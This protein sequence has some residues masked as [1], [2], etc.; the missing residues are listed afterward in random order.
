MRTR[1]R[2][3][4]LAV[5]AASGLGA[6]GLARGGAGTPPPPP[7][8]AAASVAVVVA[9]PTPVPVVVRTH[10]TVQ[11]RTQIELVAEVPGRVARVAPAL[12]A[13]G[14]FEAGDVLLELDDRDLRLALERALAARQ[15]RESER[16]LRSAEHRRL[17]ALAARE[18]ASSAR[19]EAAA[20]AERI[21]EAVLR[22]AR[23]AAAQARHD[24]ERARIRAP[25]AGRVGSRFADV[26]SFVSRGRAVARIYATDYAEVRLPVPTAEL[27]HLELPRPDLRLDAEAGGPRVRLEAPFAGRLGRWS[28]RIVRIEGEIAARTRT[29]HA[30]ARVEDPYARQREGLP[31]PVGQFVS[32]EIRGRTLE[33]AF[34]LP[35]SALDPSDRVW[36]VDATQR[37][38]AREV[39][40]ARADAGGVVVTRGLAAGERVLVDPVGA[41]EGARV[42]PVGAQESAGRVCE[43]PSACRAVSGGPPGGAPS[44]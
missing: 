22:E 32:A 21:A 37:L 27:A 28:A 8:P 26:G 5:L 38:R 42:R 23:A 41:V 39:A 19:L 43:G 10:G 9:A 15:R 12:A 18:Y 2:W 24:L 25:F 13:G 34:A 30:V 17:R 40:V 3:L 14:F 29:L 44:P 4:S 11:A 20:H 31:L 6:W 36:V 1:M 33:A 16:A 35:R 7:E